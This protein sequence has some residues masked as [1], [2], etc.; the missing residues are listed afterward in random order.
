M[1]D[2][3]LY[4]NLSQTE[5]YLF[6]MAS[7][8]K[9]IYVYR[10][11]GYI[12]VPLLYSS[13][14]RLYDIANMRDLTEIFDRK[15]DLRSVTPSLS[16][17]LYNPFID[18]VRQLNRTKAIDGNWNPTPMTLDTRLYCRAKTKT[19]LLQIY[20]SIIP[21]FQPNVNLDVTIDDSVTNDI[22]IKMIDS[23][24]ILPMIY[25]RQDKDFNEFTL[26]FHIDC[27]YNRIKKS[28]EGQEL[29]FDIITDKN[30]NLEGYDG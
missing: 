12:L 7:L 27:N 2:N 17:E 3:R 19:E 30:D 9:N 25:S 15:Y 16:Y 18:P 11:G 8:F 26:Y 4:K 20:E 13:A 21:I 14:D 29:S 1:I 10:N 28:P 22:N 6:S 5:K 23:E 24:M